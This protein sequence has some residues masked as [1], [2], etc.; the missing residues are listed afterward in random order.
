V[1]STTS[2]SATTMTSV[3]RQLG[4]EERDGEDAERA[5]EQRDDVTPLTE[6]RM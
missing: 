2:G 3:C 1:S 5:A 6:S 4:E